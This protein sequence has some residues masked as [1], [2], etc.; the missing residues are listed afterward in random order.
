MKAKS[1]CMEERM[2]G[3]Q[4]ETLHKSAVNEWPSGLK[5]EPAPHSPG[6]PKP[7]RDSDKTLP[8]PYGSVSPPQVL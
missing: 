5:V 4:I 2:G 1:K 8:L 7:E 6:L 3:G